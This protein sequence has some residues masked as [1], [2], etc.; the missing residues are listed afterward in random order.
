M[1]FIVHLFC[2]EKALLPEQE[3]RI[4]MRYTV[5]RWSAPLR[6]IKQLEFDYFRKNNFIKSEDSARK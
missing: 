6:K 2:H 4:P 3:Q 5:E 1:S